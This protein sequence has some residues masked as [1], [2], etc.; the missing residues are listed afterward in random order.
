M[1]VLSHFLQYAVLCNIL[2]LISGCSE[3]PK[4]G[5][6][7]AIEI[8]DSGAGP[9]RSDT[10]F[11]ASLVLQR[12]P[13]FDAAPYT[14]FIGGV[15]QRVIRVTRGREEVMTL[16]PTR[17]GKRIARIA[18]V[19]PDATVKGERCIGR[20]F[21]DIYRNSGTC[22]FN[23]SELLCRAP[24]TKQVFYRFRLPAGSLPPP[25]AMNALDI[26]AVIWKNDA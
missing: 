3:T 6:P 25:D 13:G 20:H 9:I 18:V 17:D 21:G 2:F 23:A 24:G 5:L 11:D 7:Y 12:L 22:S 19:H 26:E 8:S 4:Q 16:A 14:A 1:S 15:P 10:P